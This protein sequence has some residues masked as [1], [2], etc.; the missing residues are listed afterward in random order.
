MRPIKCP[1]GYCLQAV[2]PSRLGQPVRCR[3]C[4]RTFQAEERSRQAPGHGEGERPAVLPAD[5]A[6]N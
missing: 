4:T 2:A 3:G 1:H 5:E 6:T